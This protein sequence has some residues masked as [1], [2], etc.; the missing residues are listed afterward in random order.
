MNEWILK[1]RK[2]A[3]GIPPDAA[4]KSIVKNSINVVKTDYER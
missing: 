2:K 3:P 4:T 1:G